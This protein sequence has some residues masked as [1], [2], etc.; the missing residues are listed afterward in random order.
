M[1]TKRMAV[2]FIAGAA[3]LGT[4]YGGAVAWDALHLPRWAWQWE[5]QRVQEQGADTRARVL[6]IQR[7]AEEQTIR[8]IDV[9]IARLQAEKRPIP[10]SL[11]AS[12]AAAQEMIDVLENEL[13]KLRADVE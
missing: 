12:R 4:L 10:P 7:D 3:A 13:N 1:S 11:Y 5:V 2:G 8:D 9:L 6:V